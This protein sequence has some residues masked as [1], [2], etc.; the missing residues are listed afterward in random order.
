MV[1]NQ[2]YD[3]LCNVIAGATCGYT[4][5]TVLSR[6]TEVGPRLIE[7]GPICSSVSLKLAHRALQPS[8]C[9]TEVGPRHALSH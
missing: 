8:R 7:V 5:T 6:L 9:L 1:D 3:N 2:L 4:P